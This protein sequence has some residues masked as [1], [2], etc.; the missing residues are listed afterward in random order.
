MKRIPRN[1]SKHNKKSG[2]ALILMYWVNCLPD[3]I[4]RGCC[5]VLVVCMN[6]SRFC[7]FL[8]RFLARFWIDS[9]HAQSYF[10]VIHIDIESKWI[11]SCVLIC[12]ILRIYIFPGA[13]WTTILIHFNIYAKLQ[14]DC[15]ESLPHNI[16]RI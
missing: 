8:S 16:I 14:K 10:S 1:I 9:W 11:L 4:V 6:A 2:N 12:V 5:C 15:V 13:V 3:W 7:L